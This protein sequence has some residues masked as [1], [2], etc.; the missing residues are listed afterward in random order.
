MKV[1]F[2]IKRYN[3][4][5]GG[6]PRFQTYELDAEPEN[7]ILDCLH[8][9]KWKQDGTLAFRRSCGHAICGSCAMTI[10][11]ENKLACQTLVRD[12]GRR[13]TVEPLRSYPVI[14]DLI[15]DLDRFYEKFYA[16]MSWFIN[17]SAPPDRERFQSAEDQAL[18]DEA[19]SCILCACCTSACPSFWAD[20]DYLGPSAL[21]KA[22]R[23]IFDSRDQAQQARLTLLDTSKGPWKC[24]TIFNCNE[25]CP[26]EI[27]ITNAIARLKLR[28]SSL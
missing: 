17:N 16:V 28:L 7:P 27:D 1:L 18:I 26:K 6:R 20:D 12:T 4:E 5:T 11:N 14:R 15:V 8:E 22:Y 21:L 10:N 9:I 13:V 24:H 25:A 2:R 3:P 23:F 19:A